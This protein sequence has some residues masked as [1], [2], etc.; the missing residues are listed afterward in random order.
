M[1]WRKTTRL[2]QSMAVGSKGRRTP[3]P[4][5]SSA[6]LATLATVWWKRPVFRWTASTAT[7]I[8]IGIIPVVIEHKTWLGVDSNAARS[9]SPIAAQPSVPAVPVTAASEVQG[10]SCDKPSG[11]VVPDPGPHNVAHNGSTRPANAMVSSGSP[12]GVTI[13]GTVDRAVVLLGMDVEVITRKPAQHG[14]MLPPNC[15][16]DLKPRFFTVDLDAQ[17]PTLT[18]DAKG[19]AGPTIGFPYKVTTDDP[20]QWYIEAATDQEVQWHLKLRWSSGAQQGVIVIDDNGRP[21]QTTSAKLTRR[22]CPTP[23]GWEPPPCPA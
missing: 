8:F 20:E 1:V 18:A 22:F 23:R 9:G 2:I 19:S 21:F 15:A 11:W 3:R 6:Q 16:S 10:G 5:S 7:A 4:P 14:A 17:R 13:Q 12:L